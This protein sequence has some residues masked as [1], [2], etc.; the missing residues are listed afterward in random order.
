MMKRMNGHM[1]DYQQWADAQLSAYVGVV[2][3]RKADDAAHSTHAFLLILYENY[4]RFT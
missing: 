4:E 1:V 2:R 3:R